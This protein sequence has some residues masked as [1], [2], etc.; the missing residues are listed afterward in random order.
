MKIKETQIAEKVVKYLQ[1][2]GYDVYQEVKLYSRVCDIVAKLGNI[3]WAIECKT[4]FGLSVME[5]AYKWK[6][7][8]NYVS[9]AVPKV[10]NKFGY[11][12]CQD[13]GIGVFT[14]PYS[15]VFTLPYLEW[16]NIVERIKPK[17]NRN[18]GTSFMLFERQKTHCKAGTATGGYWTPFQETKKNLIKL[19]ESNPGVTFAEAIKKIDHHYATVGG[20]KSALRQWI[21]S[22][23]IPEL[24]CENI[25]GNV[26]QIFPKDFDTKCLYQ[27][28]KK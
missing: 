5:Q 11:K 10:K 21:G 28:Q 20:A 14:L 16:E 3:T 18:I 12:I 7:N 24:K 15:G 8:A 1:Q 26:L 17:L 27:N 2:M 22:S 6:Q 4:S 19:V 9:I 25:K 23:A 13:Y